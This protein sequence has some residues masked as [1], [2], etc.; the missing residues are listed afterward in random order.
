MVLA[1]ARE[2]PGPRR[3]F[4]GAGRGAY[5]C[6][7]SFESGKMSSSGVVPGLEEGQTGRVAI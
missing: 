4:A 1:S 5:F 3:P 6:R 2:F 7:Q